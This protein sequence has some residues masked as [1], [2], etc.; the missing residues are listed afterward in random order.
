MKTNFKIAMVDDDSDDLEFMKQAFRFIDKEESLTTFYSGTEL[1]NHLNS[2]H[3]LNNYPSVVLLDH[4]LAGE[5]GKE[6][7]E[8]LKQHP[9]QNK[10]T[11]II[12]SNSISAVQEEQLKNVGVIECLTKPDSF[13]KFV[14]V[15]K[16][17]MSISEKSNNV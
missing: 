11:F 13:D 2:V 3:P 6:I 7:I 9:V 17:L 12:F 10:M 4:N 1:I 8:K 14:E 15:A 16:Y 5:N